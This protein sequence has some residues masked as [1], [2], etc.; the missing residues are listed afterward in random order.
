V[1]ARDYITAWRAQAPWVS[2]H[3]ALYQRRKGR[4]LFD[5]WHGLTSAGAAAERLVACFGRY[6]REEGH[7]VTRAAFEENLARK[8]ADASFRND[9]TG[10][11]RAGVSWDID[12]AGAHVLAH[13][14]A[15][16]EGVPWRPPGPSHEPAKK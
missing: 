9:M 11:L 14:L 8:L 16:L 5:L 3:R 13:V 2:D 4:D 1:I 12:K 15:R 7:Q 10:L 6:M